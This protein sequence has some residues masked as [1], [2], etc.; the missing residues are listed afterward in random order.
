MTAH[1]S[2]VETIVI[3]LLARRSGSM[4]LIVGIDGF[5]G[6]GKSTL[7]QLL[8]RSLESA[9]VVGMD[10]FIVKDHAL[11]DSWESTW[12][13]G[14]LLEEVI[15]P[16]RAGRNV[17]YRRLEWDTNT[18]SA[19]IDLPGSAILIVEGITAFN[20]ELAGH[21]D[22]RI[23]VD[24]PPDIAK[25]RGRARDAGNENEQHWDLW[26]AND[27]RYRALHHPE[28]LADVRLSGV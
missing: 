3:D 25:A 7:A 15:L 19:P 10:D 26:S 5:G 9:T 13:R 14:R 23:W 1:S 2:T 27:E 20:P 8:A 6:S 4:E 17:R 11:D 16:F 28:D 21:Y 22:Y 24:T 18:L 12:D